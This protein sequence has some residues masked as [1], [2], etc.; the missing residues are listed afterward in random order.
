[1]C[2]ER[3]QNESQSYKRHM[4]WVIA[5]MEVDFIC[6]N[7]FRHPFVYPQLWLSCSEKQEII[8]GGLQLHPM[9]LVE[10]C[11]AVFLYCLLENGSI[12]ARLPHT[13]AARATPF[14]PAVQITFM[15]KSR[16]SNIHSPSIQASSG[17]FIGKKLS[18]CLDTLN[19]SHPKSP[20]IFRIKMDYPLLSILRL[21][22]LIMVSD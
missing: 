2:D 10:S 9:W 8:A 16:I 11:R 20:S 1:M 7:H 17:N 19:I 12:T 13:K 15:E 3:I 21:I 14:C 4:L 18:S 6:C 5:V 22:F